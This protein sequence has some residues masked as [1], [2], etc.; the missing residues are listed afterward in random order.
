MDEFI[1][2]NTSQKNLPQYVREDLTQNLAVLHTFVVTGPNG[3]TIQ[4][5]GL[6][7]ICPLARCLSWKS[8]PSFEWPSGGRLDNI[9]PLPL[10]IQDMFV[11][12]L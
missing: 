2:L 12:K 4:N 10:T 6:A 1:P 9:H 3:E 8:A 11:E 5:R 7:K